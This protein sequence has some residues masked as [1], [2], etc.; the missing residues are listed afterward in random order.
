MRCPSCASL[1]TQVKDS[2]PTEDSSVSF[3]VPSLGLRCLSRARLDGR[4]QDT[5]SRPMR[6]ERLRAPLVGE[7]RI[8]TSREPEATVTNCRK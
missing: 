1:D 5:A 7:A 4:A 8:Q 3:L 6:P 2:R